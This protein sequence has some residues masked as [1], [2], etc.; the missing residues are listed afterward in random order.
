MSVKPDVKKTFSDLHHK[1]TAVM[2]GWVYRV[3]AP[4]QDG[5]RS[6][7]AAFTSSPKLG[8]RMVLTWFVKIRLA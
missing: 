7:D 6:R 5:R 2:V 3:L 4:A 1:A 8:I